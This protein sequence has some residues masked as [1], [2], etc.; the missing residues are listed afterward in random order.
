[1]ERV[2]AVAAVA[3]PVVDSTASAAWIVSAALAV[4]P[5]VA[6]VAVAL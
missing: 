3:V 4:V 5:V 6:S 1:M 2:A